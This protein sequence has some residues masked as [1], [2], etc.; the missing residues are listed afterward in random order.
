MLS[1]AAAP[2][3]VRLELSQELACVTRP[4]LEALVAA[5][6]GYSPFDP[7][8]ARTLEVSVVDAPWSADVSFSGGRR[9]LA[10]P[11]CEGL[12]ETLAASIAVMVDPF[13]RG[14]PPPAP[15]V[16]PPPTVPVPPPAVAPPPVS[17]QAAAPHPELE[18]SGV[19]LPG[20]VPGPALGA[21]LLARLRGTLWS[22]SLDATVL[23][24]V[25]AQLDGGAVS[26]GGGLVGLLGC[27][28]WNI[29]EGCLTGRVGI[30]WLQGL[31][32]SAPRSAPWILGQLGVRA[33]VA[34]PRETRVFGS[35]A[36]EVDL[37]L[38]RAE[39]LLGGQTI[40]SAPLVTGRV[41]LGFG[42][43]L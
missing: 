4:A 2:P 29:V 43:R 31:D 36:G 26:A 42:V 11:T 38:R 6:L 7:G 19:W 28:H 15:E 30:A 9:H 25:R 40:W 17:P 5:R 16:Q 23:P 35:L 37:P 20:T 27:L 41:T 33:G 32:V 18:L 39:L 10:A 14:R 21:A 22:L 3:R 34:W 13:G 24:P 8:T 12:I 1:L